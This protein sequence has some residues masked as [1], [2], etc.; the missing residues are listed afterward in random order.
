ML[1]T[2]ILTERWSPSECTIQLLNWGVKLFLLPDHRQQS[3][4]MTHCE[5][6]WNGNLFGRGGGGAI[7]LKLVII[8]LHDL[9]QYFT[10]YVYNISLSAHFRHSAWVLGEKRENCWMFI[11]VTEKQCPPPLHLIELR[12]PRRECFSTSRYCTPLRD[13]SFFLYEWAP[14]T[15][16]FLSLQLSDADLCGPM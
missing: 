2:V 15:I 10:W 1:Y 8:P 6:E 13:I 3:V 4:S 9:S 7:A 11:F 5:V 12:S 16:S 14:H